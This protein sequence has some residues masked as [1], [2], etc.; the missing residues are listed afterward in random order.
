M[1]NIELGSWKVHELW[2]VEWPAFKAKVLS[3]DRGWWH[4]WTDIHVEFLRQFA[5]TLGHI[6][7]FWPVLLLILVLL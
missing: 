7:Q 2:T 6:L 5:S 1:K 4:E 3:T